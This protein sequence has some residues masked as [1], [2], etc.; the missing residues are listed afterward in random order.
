MRQSFLPFSPP[1]VG[2][3]EIAEV[4]RTLRSGWLTTGPR[5]K[6]FEDRFG[7]FVQAQGALALSS[8]TAA[9][10][11]ALLV[12]GVGPGDHVITTPM[13]FCS[14]LH[15][16]E[17]LGATPVLVDV[18]PD[19]LNI[20]PDRVEEAVR[21]LQAE[22]KRCRVI[23]PVHLYGQ[24]ADMDALIAIARPFQLAIVEDAA[25]ALPASF[26]GR[27]VGSPVDP[28]GRVTNLVAFSFYATKNLTTGEGGMLTGPKDLVDVGRMWSLHGMSKDA[29]QR[30]GPGGSWRYDVVAPGFKYN[31]TDIQAALGLSQLAKLAGFRERRQQIVSRYRAGL[32]GCEQVETPETRTDREH[33][34]HLFVIRLNLDTLNI[35]RGG[36]IERLKALRIGTSVHFIPVHHHP[37]YRDRYG[38]HDDDLPVA[39][40]EFKRIISLPMSPSLTDQDVDDVIEAVASVAWEHRR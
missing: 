27:P 31:M 17:Q 24:P 6:L 32:A 18:Q 2:D 9:L 22:G 38:Y 16:I 29:Y 12:L 14:C 5:V 33:A 30:Y 1:Q 28:G 20:D 26:Q 37:Y 35:D 25:H 40:R 19:T 13:T 21:R 10:H 3:E 39:G 7:E 11:L 8:G 36:F 23:M 34:W 4:V 15:V